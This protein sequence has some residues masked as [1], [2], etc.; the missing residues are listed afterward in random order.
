VIGS[1]PSQFHNRGIPLVRNIIFLDFWY[2][3]CG[4]FYNIEILL[5]CLFISD[6]SIMFVSVF[7]FGSPCLNMVDN[8]FIMV[9]DEV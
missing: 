6:G 9:D 1:I 2:N 4:C 5:I 3:N 8:C 7:D